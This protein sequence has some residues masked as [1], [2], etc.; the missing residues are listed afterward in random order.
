MLKKVVKNNI[1]L[2]LIQ[3]NIDINAIK[4]KAD[5]TNVMTED[6]VSNI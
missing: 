6:I 3:I 1:T 4:I 5:D 2:G